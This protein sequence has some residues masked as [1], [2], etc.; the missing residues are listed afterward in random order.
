MEKSNEEKKQTVEKVE[1]ILDEIYKDEV[2]A[3]DYI[4][5]ME[6]YNDDL[7]AKVKADPN[8]KFEYKTT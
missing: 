5:F 6:K 8:F 3:V 1:E 4:P 7:E 2:K